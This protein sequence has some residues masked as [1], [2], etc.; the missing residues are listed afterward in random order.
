VFWACCPNHFGD[1]GA[2]LPARDRL[3]TGSRLI[4]VHRSLSESQPQHVRHSKTRGISCARLATFAAAGGTPALR[5][6]W[7]T[8]PHD[9]PPRP[10]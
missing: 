9:A 2:R 3:A 7:A 10:S 6:I 5:S 4:G 8:R 1:G